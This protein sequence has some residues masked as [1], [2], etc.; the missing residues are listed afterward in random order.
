M[1]LQKLLSYVRRAVEDYNMIEHGDKI[2]VGISGGKDSI[3]LL[4]ALKNLQRFYPKHFEL[5]AITV[6]LGLPNANYDDIKHFCHEIGV[7]Y[8]VVNTDIAQIIFEERKE[9]NPCSLCAKM[10]KGAL[11]DMAEQL[12]C[13]KVALGHNKD[14]VVE[15]FFMSLF[16]EG[17]INC[18][19]PVSFLDRKQ[20]YS[21]RPLMYVPEP[22][23]KGFIQKSGISIVKN[24]CIADGNTKRQETKQL[25]QS[26]S[27]DYK[28]L[29]Q[30]VF[31]AIQRSD[32]KGWKL[33]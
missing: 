6:S 2:A 9:K 20:I 17:R 19:S 5:E 21:I 13:N 4:L 28:N 24:P 30:K 18:F 11:N 31:G 33:K 1:K 16:Y 7:N 12:N 25:L 32:I 27:K 29:Q 26:L 10:R 14:D 23:I 8:T 15:T 3:C 22:E